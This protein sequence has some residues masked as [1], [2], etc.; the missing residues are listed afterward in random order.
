MVSRHRVQLITVQPSTMASNGFSEKAGNAEIR[1]LAQAVTA[2][3]SVPSMPAAAPAPLE[4][5]SRAEIAAGVRARPTMQNIS[6][7]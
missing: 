5:A 1:A 4:P 7:E 3:Y 6:I 2:S